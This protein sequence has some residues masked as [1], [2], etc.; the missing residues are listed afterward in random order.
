MYRY[1]YSQYM[2]R[3]ELSWEI[4]PTMLC[5]PF[6]SKSWTYYDCMRSLIFCSLSLRQKSISVY[7]QKLDGN[8][9]RKII[10]VFIAS[11][12]I[13]HQ[14]ITTAF[15]KVRIWFYE[16][17]NLFIYTT[18]MIFWIYDVLLRFASASHTCT[19][20]YTWITLI[21]HYPC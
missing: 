16:A 20:I 9:N 4:W 19:Y 3:W 6:C 10:N 14:L 18:P 13:T 8:R 1:T 11:G 5:S 17:R 7:K 21:L 2:E 12:I 15:N